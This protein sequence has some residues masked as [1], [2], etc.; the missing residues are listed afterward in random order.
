MAAVLVDTDPPVIGHRQQPMR[1]SAVLQPAPDDPC[2]LLEGYG[3]P[4]I[5]A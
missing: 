3:A 2:R 4:E 5:V 1:I